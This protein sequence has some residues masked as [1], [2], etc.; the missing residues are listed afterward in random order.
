M[1]RDFNQV[2]TKHFQERL[3]DRLARSRSSEQFALKGALLFVALEDGRGTARGRP[4]RDI[5]TEA[6]LSM[7]RD[8]VGDRGH[9]RHSVGHL[10]RDF[11]LV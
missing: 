5:G 4:T 1:D 3:L 7:D 8:R 2:L 6:A 10:A 9:D 11:D